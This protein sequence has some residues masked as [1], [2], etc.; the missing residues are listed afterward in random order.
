MT[1]FETLHLVYD[2]YCTF[3][4]RVLK[5]FCTI[6]IMRV[7]QLHDANDPDT[8]NIRFPMLHAADVAS[9]MYGVTEDGQIYRGLFAFRRM[10]WA[11]PITW[12][13]LV[14]FYFPSASFFGC[15]SEVCALPEK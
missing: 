6:D 7:L 8:I 14:L 4:I 11:N 3:C 13:L 5:I 12:P 15:N 10:M 1:R 2:G 9:A